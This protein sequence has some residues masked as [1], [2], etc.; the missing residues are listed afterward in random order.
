MLNPDEKLLTDDQLDNLQSAL[1]SGSETASQALASWI[2]KPSLVEIDSLEQLPLN[3][4]TAV[5]SDDEAP[6]C[7]CAM[8]INGAI[9]G[10]MI[11][12]F[13]DSSGLAL[14]D[15]LLD[16]Q[17]GTTTEWTELA[18]SAALE[19]TNILCCAYLNAL[20]MQLSDVN[21][22]SALVP[23]PPRFNRDF[24]ASLMEFA[25]MDQAIAFDHALLTRTRF[26]IDGAPVTWTLLFVPDAD[27]MARLPALLINGDGGS[28][29]GSA[30]GRR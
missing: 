18:T 12:V 14:A 29:E 23:N 26:Q 6:V 4:A 10:Q 2:G 11:L 8:E 9:S 22:T 24:A 3:Q 15:M 20:S 25:L 16:R 19:T 13:D 17:P 7:Y 27:S 30:D 21:G 28:S 1:H 5:L